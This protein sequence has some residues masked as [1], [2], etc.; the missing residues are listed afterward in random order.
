MV[1]END[2]RSFFSIH[3]GNYEKRNAQTT[4]LKMLQARLD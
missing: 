2:Q 3:L 4:K 1:E